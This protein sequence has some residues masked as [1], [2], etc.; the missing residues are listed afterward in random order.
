MSSIESPSWSRYLR[1]LLTRGSACN[2]DTV[3]AGTTG[4][5]SRRP[6]LRDQGDQSTRPDGR[7]Y[8][9]TSSRTR[10]LKK[11]LGLSCF[12]LALGCGTG[13]PSS[14]SAAT[15]PGASD[16]D[17]RRPRDAGP[18]PAFDATVA[19]EDASPPITECTRP[20]C[21]ARP[22]VFVHGS[23]GSNDDWQQVLYQLVATD[24]RYDGFVLAGTGDHDWQ[25][26]SIERR[27]WLF[28]FDYYV[29][30]KADPRGSYTA[31][32]GRIGSNES[33]KCLSPPGD[34][35][36][37]STSADYTSGYT[38]EYARDLTSMIDDVIRATG[39]D[40]VDIVAHSMGGLVAR[41]YVSFFGGNAKIERM[42]LIS[43]PVSGVP[44][45]SIGG[46]LGVGESWMRAHELAELDQGSPVAAVRFVS[47]GAS[48][49]SAWPTRLLS[50][51]TR[52]AT[53]PELWVLTG[54]LDALVSYQSAEHPN[55]REHDV[56][57]GT[58]HTGILRH[59]KTVQKISTLCGGTL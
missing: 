29:K 43:S 15:S 40:T 12:T 4:G 49:L 48:E 31:G 59:D 1:A 5:T 18:A 9:S 11:L 55:Q 26:K 54:Q 10:M 8:L 53:I 45:A 39:T 2:F 21:A 16:A 14:P 6:V 46:I 56:V 22:I 23:M 24:P 13:E 36:I 32:P 27:R 51:E 28:A 33:H 50:F 3:P 38:H 58:D 37:L 17:D 25:P 30:T 35:H 20:P 57:G 7:R 34:G 41:S 42:L 19:S 47:C 52:L 44:L